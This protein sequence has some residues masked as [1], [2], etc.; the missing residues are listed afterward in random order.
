MRARYEAGGLGYGEAK[1]ALFEVLDAYLREPRARYRALM[2]DP[3][4]LDRA[5]AAGAA[6]VR[7]R[8]AATIDRMRSAV[9]I[10]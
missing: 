10:A 1:A 5:L 6:R 3:G 7:E 8:A 2:A 4:E 9:G